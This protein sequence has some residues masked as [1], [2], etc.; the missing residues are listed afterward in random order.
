MLCILTFADIHD[1]LQVEHGF[2]LWANGH[3]TIDIIESDQQ[4]GMKFRFIGWQKDWASTFNRWGQGVNDYVVLVLRMEPRNHLAWCDEA[5]QMAKNIVKR[6]V[7]ASPD[8]LHIILPPDQKHLIFIFRPLFLLSH[9]PDQQH[10]IFVHT[11]LL[12]LIS[13]DQQ[14]LIFSPNQCLI[15]IYMTLFLLSSSPDQQCLV[16]ISTLLLL[17]S[18]SPDSN[19][20]FPLLTSNIWVRRIPS[21]SSPCGQNFG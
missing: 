13:S 21:F 10:L 8:Q 17:S 12:K 20:S 6:T 5:R 19:I 2:T 7:K 16:F 3:L 4:L 14:H 1:V 18:H 15:F 11:L 9:S